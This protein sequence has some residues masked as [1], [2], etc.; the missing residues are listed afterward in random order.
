[1]PFVVLVE[2][3][4]GGT[5]IPRV[6]T[7]FRHITNILFFILAVY[8]ALYGVTYAYQLHDIANVIAGWLVIVQISNS[9]ISL[10]RLS[11]IIEG[12]ENPHTGQH[13]KKRP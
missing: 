12:R 1:M 7:S 2:S 3:L 6:A 11:R 4:T 8:A 10:G 9:D 13:T 5:M